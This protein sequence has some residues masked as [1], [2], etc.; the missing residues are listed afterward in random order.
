[1][2]VREVVTAEQILQKVSEEMSIWLKERKIDSLE[3]LGKSADDYV[4]ARKSEVTC[5]GKPSPSVHKQDSKQGQGRDHEER[6]RAPYEGYRGLQGGGRAHQEGGRA[7]VNSRG[8][9]WGAF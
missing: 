7:Q 6:Y 9:K 5:L 3:K 2:S 8:G 1:M 4:L